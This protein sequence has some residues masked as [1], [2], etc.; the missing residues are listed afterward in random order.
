M[1]EK[2][3]YFNKYCKYC[4]HFEKRQT[5]DPCYECLSYPSNED[6]RKPV[7]FEKDPN[8][9]IRAHEIPEIKP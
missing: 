8:K 9:K 5:D 4:I 3:V 6:S 1:A 7:R 2:E